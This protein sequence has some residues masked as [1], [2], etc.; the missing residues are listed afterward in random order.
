LLK[1]EFRWA[2][3]TVCG[4]RRRHN[5]EIGTFASSRILVARRWAITGA[6]Y[7]AIGGGIFLA[8]VGLSLRSFGLIALAL[9]VKAMRVGI[10][11]QAGGDPAGRRRLVMMLLV[12]AG[13]LGGLEVAR[14][15]GTWR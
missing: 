5:A 12:S 7:S 4:R 13:T 10:E 3:L 1:I 6:L 9:G 15:M 2:L 11:I 14:M 8:D